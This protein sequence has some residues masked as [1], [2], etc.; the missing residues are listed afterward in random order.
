M[1]IDAPAPYVRTLQ[2]T[3]RDAARRLSELSDPV[4]TWRP[5]PAA[6]S[7]KEIIGHLIDSAANNHQRFVRAADQ[8]DL[9]FPGYEQNRWVRVQAYDSAP[10]NELVT[11]WAT[12][13]QH[14]ARVM[15]A[16]PSSV[17]ERRH[18]RHNLHEIGWRPF[19][20]DQPAT[21]DDLMHDYVLHLE[22]HLAQV[23]DRLR[24]AH[25]ASIAAAAGDAAAR[26]A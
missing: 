22:H 24:G 16:V 17:R 14:L 13:N 15:A 3:T 20:A 1:T 5:S 2:D 4:I 7:I 8:D 26:D 10:W 9:V 23:H 19:P 21:L 25:A 12:Y 11:L 18:A 6:W